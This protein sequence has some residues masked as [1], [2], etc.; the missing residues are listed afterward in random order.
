MAPEGSGP[1][2]LGVAEAA[3]RRVLEV[4]RRSGPPG[5][6]ATSIAECLLLQLDALDLADDGARLA[7]AVIA[8]HLPA[9]A[10]GHFSS[11]AAAH[12]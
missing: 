10:R 11:I 5:I 8:E 4:I 9:L 1:P 12:P 2:E 3:V 7:R 6:G